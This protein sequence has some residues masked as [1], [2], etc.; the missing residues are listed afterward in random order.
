MFIAH[1]FSFSFSFS[2]LS[3]CNEYAIS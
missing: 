2:F 1:A 3:K